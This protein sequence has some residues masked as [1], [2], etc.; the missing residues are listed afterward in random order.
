MNRQYDKAK[1]AKV[2]I[3]AY[4]VLA[5]AYLLFLFW[6]NQRVVAVDVSGCEIAEP[7]QFEYGFDRLRCEYGYA[8]IRGYAYEKGV[9]VTSAD[10]AVLAHDPATGAYYKLPTKVVQNKKLTKNADDGCDYDYAQFRA[11][12]FLDKFPA[13]STVCIW[14][15]VNGE[16]K[17]IQTDEVIYHY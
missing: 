6:T 12:A 1:V 4:A 14:Y 7:G 16:N 15:R 17:L 8:D 2:L 13:G 3:G 10:T 11:V 9:S 5:L